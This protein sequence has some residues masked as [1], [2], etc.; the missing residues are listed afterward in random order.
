[1]R[2]NGD[3]YE[4]GFEMQKY[5]GK[6]EWEYKDG[7]KEIGHWVENKKQGEFKC[8]DKSGTLTHTNIY[9]GGKEIE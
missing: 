3:I 4:G 5:H 9:E 8:Y 1:M 2:D 7:S 6:G